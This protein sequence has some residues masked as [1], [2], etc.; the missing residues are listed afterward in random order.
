M[1]DKLAFVFPGQGSQSVGMLSELAGASDL[2]QQTFEEASERLEVNLWELS[3]QGP[4]ADLNRTANTQ[5][6]MLAAGVATWRLWQQHGGPL[7]ELLAG[8]SLGEYSALVAANALGLEDAAW[9]V[10]QRGRLMQ[11]AVPEGEGAMA[12]VLGVDQ[13]VLEEICQ[14]V[15]DGDIVAPANLNAPGQTVLSGS[16]PAIERAVEAAKARGA[17]RAIIL[18]VS[19]PCHCDLLKPGAEQ[20]AGHLQQ[21]ELHR[22]EIPVIQNAEVQIYSEPG[23]IRAALVRQLY[24]PVRWIETIESMA[25]HG[26]S[27]A[28]ECGPGKVLAG[29]MRR[30]DRSIAAYPVMDTAS[31][32]KA[33]AETAA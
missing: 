22:P 27:R 9:L 28:V 23:E 18:P 6:A 24:Q 4:E 13:P 1:T 7:P 2:I 5:P 19:V 15:A 12:A 16:T 21:V 20:L 10:A 26:V 29:L 17:R 25:K 30:I 11:E 8:H 33:L 32:D 14:Q 31:L 3:Q